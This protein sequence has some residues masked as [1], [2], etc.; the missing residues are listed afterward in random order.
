[1]ETEFQNIYDQVLK[2]IGSSDK[3]LK[4]AIKWG[5]L[6]FAFKGDFHHWICAVAI[7]KQSV[8]LTFHFGGILEDKNKKFVTGESFFLRKLAYKDLDEVDPD[9]IKDFINQAIDK[10]DYFKDNWK[11]L[12]KEKSKK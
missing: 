4:S 2:T 5:K 3:N 6:T 12:N 10:L 1:M 7:T 11:E 9:V 8:N